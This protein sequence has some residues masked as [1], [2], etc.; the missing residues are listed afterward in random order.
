M[1]ITS[2]VLQPDGAGLPSKRSVMKLEEMEEGA[3]RV[4]ILSGRGEEQLTRM[5]RLRR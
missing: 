4:G 3:L 5:R 2:C 1:L